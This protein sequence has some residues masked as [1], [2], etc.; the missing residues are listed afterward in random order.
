MSITSSSSGAGP[1]R[2]IT[3][4]VDGYFVNQWD[5]SCVVALEEKHLAYSTARALL[6]PGEEWFG[7]ARAFMLAGAAAVVA[8]QWDVEDRATARLMSE[9][10]SRLARGTALARALAQALAA[11]AHGGEHPIDWAGF[12]VLGGPGVLADD[13][14]AEPERSADRRRD[15]NRLDTGSP[16]L[17]RRHEGHRFPERHRRDPNPSPAGA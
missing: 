16:A 17:V 12:A 15:S 13:F 3:L 5:A 4:Y 2:V 6:R 10:Y 1:G 7:L 14:G 8:A 9:L 11:R